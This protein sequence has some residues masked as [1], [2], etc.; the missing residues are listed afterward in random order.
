MIKC[1]DRSH[2]REKRLVMAHGHRRDT[3]RYGRKAWRKNEAIP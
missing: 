3:D 1:P 2:L